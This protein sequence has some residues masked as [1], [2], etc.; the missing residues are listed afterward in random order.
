LRASRFAVF[1][2]SSRTTAW[3]LGAIALVG[4]VA[5]APMG[6]QEE[7]AVKPSATA[8]SCDVITAKQMEGESSVAMAL[9][10][11]V[12]GLQLMPTSGQAGTGSQLN[13]RG[14]NSTRSKAPLVFVDGLLIGDVRGKGQ[15]ITLIDQMNPNDVMLIEV[16][17]GP[18]AT[19]LYGTNAAGGVIR[20]YTKHG[21]PRAELLTDLRAQCI[22]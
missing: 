7:R 2:A 19:T 6:A 18:A 3:W 22:P 1:Q 11:H 9:R 17:R 15:S 4:T 21:N 20:I 14:I 16:F 5:P 8:V 12:T 13:L 10:G